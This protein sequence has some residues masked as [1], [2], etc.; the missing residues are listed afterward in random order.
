MAD[1]CEA[2][3]R[4]VMKRMQRARRR[5]F[6]AIMGGWGPGA[7][8]EAERIQA[9]PADYARA[10]ARRKAREGRAGVQGGCTPALGGAP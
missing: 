3:L 2:T 7:Q 8:A 5:T 1:L 10:M 4:S 9:W 6:E